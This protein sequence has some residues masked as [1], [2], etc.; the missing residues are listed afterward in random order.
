MS[1]R[2]PPAI[3]WLLCALFP[4]CTAIEDHDA[5][6]YPD[7]VSALR[8]LETA[9]QQFAATAEVPQRLDFPGQGRVVVRQLALD[10]YPGNTYVRC[11]F[12]Y[13]NNTGRPV[14]RSL[15]SLDVLDGNGAMVA[16]QVS[17]CI[18]PTPRA[19]YDGTFFADELRTQTYGVHTQAGWTW[20]LTCKTE[21]EPETED[22]V[23]K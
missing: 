16:S 19:I 17:V 15:V 6:V 23:L 7:K 22:A 2:S 4:A 10:G 21:F 5:S 18:F 14:V 11:R 3:L 9:Q 20:R 1:H 8:E 12:H 13:L